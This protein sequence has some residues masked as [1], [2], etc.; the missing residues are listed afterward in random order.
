VRL[1]IL[2]RD[3]VINHDSDAFIKT[4][5]EWVPIQGSLEA[6]ARLNRH[7]YRVAIATNQSGIAR[8]LLD[9]DTLNAI[10]AQLHQRLEQLGGQI[11]AVFF[12]P[13]GPDDRCN[14]RKP[15]IGM[16]Q[17]I[18]SRFGTELIA[19]PM[20]G[21]S[22]RDIQAYRRVGGRAILVK[23]GKGA[24]TLAEQANSLYQ[25]NIFDDLAAV[26]DW[27][28]RRINPERAP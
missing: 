20:V 7:G 18:R 8:R 3:G 14:C 25:V 2:D 5:S 17:Q 22:L 28:L 4:P 6:I 19:V 21:D 26:V 24:A 12:C 11:D 15:G 23:T 9:I 16:L 27:L 13:H 1:I 10:H